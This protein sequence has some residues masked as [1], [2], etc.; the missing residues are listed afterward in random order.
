L[1]TARELGAEP[2]VRRV[3]D[4]L[5]GCG[6]AVPRGPRRSTQANAAGLTP[7]QV[8]VL[9]LVVSGLSN[10]DIAEQ[11]VLS[12]RT[13]EHHVAAV[14]RKLGTSSRHAAARRAAELGMLG[15]PTA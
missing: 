2:L 9:E 8:E 3:S 4:R 13:V 15:R 5:R 12:E 11:L 14:L 1:A 6:Y 10:L 7:R